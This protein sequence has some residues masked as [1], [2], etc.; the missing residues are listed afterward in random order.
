MVTM[1]CLPVGG[2]YACGLVAAGASVLG[3]RGPREDAG[4]RARRAGRL[5]E[6]CGLLE[7]LSGDLLERFP[8]LRPSEH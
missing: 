6:I 2:L 8:G 3:L 1:D 5:G 4:A 7:R